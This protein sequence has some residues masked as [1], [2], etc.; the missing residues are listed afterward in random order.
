MYQLYKHHKHVSK[1]NQKADEFR[2]L[3]NRKF[4]S[5]N[6]W[7]ALKNYNMSL[8]FAELGSSQAALAYGNRSAVYFEVK[9][10]GKCLENI[11]QAIDAGFPKE[12]LQNLS[13]REQSCLKAMEH[14]KSDPDNDPWNFFKLSYP[15][16]DKLPFA[17]DCL[18]LHENEKYG[19][20]IVTNRYLKPG[21]VIVLEETP[22]KAINDSGKYVRC[23][24]C[25]KSNKMSLI[26]MESCANGKIFYLQLSS[27]LPLSTEFSAMFCSSKCLEYGEKTLMCAT[28]EIANVSRILLQALTFVDD[29][30]KRLKDLIDDPEL[31]KK[32]I[33][34]FDMS[35]AS[36]PAY[37]LHQFLATCSFVKKRMDVCIQVIEFLP[38][39]DRWPLQEDK[40]VAKHIMRHIADITMNG[41]GFDWWELRA[42]GNDL[43]PKSRFGIEVFMIG[44]GIFPFASLFNHS[45]CQNAE[46]FSVDNKLAVVVCL[47]IKKGEQVFISYG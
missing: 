14:Y 36:D 5:S 2:G 40:E 22:F 12:K 34:D 25:F 42:D 15:P 10:Y 33:F 29:D 30:L 23:A 17:A 43:Y 31:K 41:L 20:H 38:V 39:L 16:N 13:N 32:T 4:K 9:E 47:P 46:R 8:S 19:R 37:E 1:S 11:K 27:Q 18:E 21:D 35:Y 7:E 24:N 6:F 28:D 44:N 3:G 45:C 26:P